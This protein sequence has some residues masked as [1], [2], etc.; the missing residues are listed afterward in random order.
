M[1]S[2]YP[3]RATV[4]NEYLGLSKVIRAMSADE[5]DWL[6]EAQLAKWSEQETRKRQQKQKETE[7]EA[8]R[9][10]AENLK[11]QAEE[12]T[13]A[14]QQNIENF[15]SI[16]SRS[17]NESLALDWEQLLDRRSFRPFQFNHPRPNRDTIRLQLLGPEPT[18]RHVPSPLPEE[19]SFLEIF[20]PFLRRRRLERETTATEMCEQQKKRAKA[21]FA[22]RLK[23]YRLRE[24]EVVEAYNAAVHAYNHKLN[25]EKEKYVR[26]RNEFLAQQLTHN[27][28]VLAFRSRYE[29]G[30]PE[31]VEQY[32]QMV[33]ERSSY[34]EPIAGEAE[35]RFDE[36][37]KT[38]IVSFWLPGPAD[39]PN[40]VE[41]K[42]IV[43]RKE[44]K[45]SAMKQKEFQAFYDDVIHQIALRTVHEVFAADYALRA[46][47]VVFNGWVR[48]TD[49]QTGKP[50]TSCILSY[51][52]ARKQFMDLDLAHVA[53]KECIR[54][55]KGITAG[56]LLMLAPVKPI[57]ELKR[58][59]DR[60]VESKDVLDQLRPE[61]NLAAMEW[62]DF[63]HLVRQ[64]FEKEFAKTG[65]EVRVTQA[66]RDRGVDAIA[67]DPDP[68]R[69]GKF[70]IQAKRYN[71]VVPVSAV[72]DLYGTMIAEGATKGIL[73][74]TSYYGRDSREFAKDKPITLINGENLA[75]M[76][77]TYGYNV[78]IAL[79]AKGDP[80][81][82]LGSAAS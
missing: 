49:R 23:E 64:L 14:A 4:R 58:D 20:L 39:V 57:M 60:F 21:E 1:P 40:I 63:E 59:D 47:A 68:I 3:Y 66:S 61:D 42:Y 29:A 27:S 30:S 9:Q 75:H 67:F 38:V 7:R 2:Q 62:E 31:A 44:I 80:G 74:T 48:A 35:V 19:I 25:E 53:P 77:Q 70:V 17:L 32:T 6:V 56:P 37:S 65:G 76:F 34:P 12:D 26:Q 79:L 54:G 69:G 10:H 16:L 22:K 11:W 41:Y 52:A 46:E 36:P 50:F 13:T 45:P 72:R 33:L 82:G 43:S 78:H 18:E 71:M 28:A 55:L 51:E 81:R 15:R 24:K 73:V 8:A 5:L